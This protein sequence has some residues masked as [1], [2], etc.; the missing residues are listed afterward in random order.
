MEWLKSCLKRSSI[1]VKIYE[2]IVLKIRKIKRILKG[3]MIDRPRSKHSYGEKNKDKTFFVM[4]TCVG[5]GIYSN[6]LLNLPLMEYAM[7]KGYI[8]VFDF[9][10]SYNAMFQDEDKRGKENAW[11]YYYKQPGN[12]SLEEVYQS[13]RV[14]LCSR[15]AYPIKIPNWNEMFPANDRDL[16]Y[17]HKFIVDNIHLQKSLEKRI[18]KATNELFAGK[19]KILGVGVRAGYRALGILK[20]AAINGHPKVPTC[21]EMIQIVEQ[22][23]NQWGYGYIFLSVDDREY[24]QKFVKYF[25]DK[26]ICLE[27]HLKHYFEKDIPVSATENRDLFRCEYK[28]ITIREEME[29]YITEIYLLSACDGLCSCIGGGAQFA[30]FLNGGKYEHLDVYNEGDIIL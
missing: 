25:G 30:Y 26:C 9:Q 3:V 28:D 27:R 24:Q 14:I 22:K 7:K 4:K 29:E 15:D 21:E 17:W 11:E 2:C 1:I 16:Q 20:S 10:N 8:P 18:E 5:A 13:K 6:I 19:E 12:V 23:M